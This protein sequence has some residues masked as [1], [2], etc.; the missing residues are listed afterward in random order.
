MMRVEAQQLIGENAL[1]ARDGQAIYAQIYPE[2]AAGHPVEL[3][4]EGVHTF[5]TPF[6]NT[7]IGQLYKDLYSEQLSR[8]L[9]ISNLAPY[10]R[11]S[12]NRVIANAKRYYSEPNFKAAMDKVMSDLSQEG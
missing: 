12:L 1:T 8:L 5:S 10:A 11:G 3:D 6:F 2:L 9:I 4:F 7:A